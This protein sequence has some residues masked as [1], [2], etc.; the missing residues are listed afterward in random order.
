MSN[1]VSDKNQE[2]RKKK[3]ISESYTSD[4]LATLTVKC[5]V[6]LKAFHLQSSLTQNDFP[7]LC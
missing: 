6:K 5:Q 7:Q 2:I 1:D 3:I 4:A